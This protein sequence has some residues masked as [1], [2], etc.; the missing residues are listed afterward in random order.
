MICECSTNCIHPSM[1]CRHKAT[2]KYDVRNCGIDIGTGCPACIEYKP[3]PTYMLVKLPESEIGDYHNSA[4][5]VDKRELAEHIALKISEGFVDC[6]NTTL[7]QE[8][9][10]AIEEFIKG[11]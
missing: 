1:K 2:H 7:E 9:L 5:P 10:Q 6:K 3:E 11:E 4:T 8:A